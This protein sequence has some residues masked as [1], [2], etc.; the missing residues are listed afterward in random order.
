MFFPATI[1]STKNSVGHL[2]F[3]SWHMESFQGRTPW[4]CLPTWKE[5]QG[6]RTNVMEVHINSVKVEQS[7]RSNKLEKEWPPILAIQSY[8]VRWK[9]NFTTTI[10]CS[11]PLN[12]QQFLSFQM[13]YVAERWKSR[14]CTFAKK[15]NL[16]C[17]SK[18]KKIQKLGRRYNKWIL[19]LFFAY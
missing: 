16:S 18:I 6:N 5:R 7:R 2:F 14:K 1:V 9:I 10:G 15:N 8:K 12:V 13:N 17:V 11:M 3:P 19:W 4:S